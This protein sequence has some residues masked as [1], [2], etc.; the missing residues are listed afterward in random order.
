MIISDYINL[1]SI[2]NE[3]YDLV[4]C[5]GPLYHLMSGEERTKCI[6]ECKR[7][8]KPKGILAVA[9][10]SRFATFLNM[11]HRNASNINDFGLRN[12]SKIGKDVSIILLI[13]KLN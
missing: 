6:N 2:Q 13:R 8:L 3:T 10:I 5:L 4:M 11:I 1:E 9:Y 12:I 7:I